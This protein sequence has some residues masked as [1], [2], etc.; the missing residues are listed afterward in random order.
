M[1]PSS[2]LREGI[3]LFTDVRDVNKFLASRGVGFKTNG[4]ELEV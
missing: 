2:L 4:E 1:I 3:G